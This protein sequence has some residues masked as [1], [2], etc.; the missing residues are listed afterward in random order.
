MRGAFLFKD[1][2]K[3]SWYISRGT[4]TALDWS[5]PPVRKCFF[6]KLS[7]KSGSQWVTK[8]GEHP[9]KQSGKAPLDGASSL[10]HPELNG[11]TKIKDILGAQ[12]THSEG[13]K[14]TICGW[15]KSVRTVG[16]NRFSFIDVNDGSHV[17]NLQV[18]IDSSIPNYRE[19]SRLLT[20]DAVECFGELKCSLG[21][22]QQVELCVE[23]STKAHYVKLLGR[24]DQ[25]EKS[26]NND[27]E[28]SI[29]ND[30]EK[31][32]YSDR[33]K[34]G[35]SDREKCDG[36][37]D[38]VRPG[39]GKHYAIAKKYHTKEHL[40][41]FPHLRART[42]LYSS[43]FRLKSDIIT[44]T[45]KFWRE[46]NCTYIN[47]PVLTSNDCE[48][49][50]KLFH[51]TTL[52]LQGNQ[53][54]TVTPSKSSNGEHVN[55]SSNDGYGTDEACKGDDYP[56][57]GSSPLS[58]SRDFFKKPCYLNVSSQLTLE[59]LCCSMGDVFT[60]NQSFRAEN[61]NTVRH[62]SEFL[63]M[64]V[65]LAFSN[66]ASII[67]LAEEYIKAMVNFALHKSE[68]VN[69]LHEHHDQTL[70]QK[71]QNVLQKP[72][73][74]ITYDEAV[75]VIKQHMVQTDVLSPRTTDLTFEEQK[76]LTD[77]HFC[78]PVVV[79]NYPQD[80]KP[81]YMTLNQ[82]G[83]TVACMDIL[84]PDVGEVV[85][86][87][88]REIRIHTLERRMKEKRL[89]LRLYEPYLE[90]RRHGNIPHAGFGLG[91]DRLLM[92]LTSMSNIRDVVPFPRSPGSLFM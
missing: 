43:V 28:K 83:K 51:A 21:K 63:M 15:V 90:L 17:K 57:E 32:G 82:D 29:D 35:G 59:C 42:K 23:D 44:E 62:L 70:K 89:D 49:A 80:M 6:A 19:V 73:V 52:M 47:T 3:Y 18:V 46:K 20:D 72:F 31:R 10:Q 1:S 86:G 53:K 37:D 30:K 75:Q 69:Y 27:R 60:L 11:R 4:H 76:F 8:D 25:G 39:P 24:V 26:S 67:S 92:F 22:K 16:K 14:Y 7:G 71:L 74:V 66:L 41:N 56:H 36:G 78:S 64:E 33:D 55:V 40:R 81:F 48:G 13:K 5:R 85:G 58:F 77:V 45:F 65:E 91:I 2:T 61:S 54:E 84:L 68:D 79:I 88:E 12:V 34:S 38:G 50:G 87:S 9:A